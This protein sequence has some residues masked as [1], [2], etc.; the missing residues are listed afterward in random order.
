M[1]TTYTKLFSSIT[2]STVW[3]EDDHTRLVWITMLAMADK[4]GRIWASV[5]GLADRARVPVES[6]RH[7]LGR[8]TAPD[9]DSR[10]KEH[11][12]RRVEPIDGGWRLLNHGKYRE[13]RD[14]EAERERKR[15]WARKK[16]AGVKN[17]ENVDAKVDGIDA[18]DRYVDGSRHK[19]EASPDASA[20]PEEI[21]NTHTSGAC[22]GSNGHAKPDEPSPVPKPTESA[23]DA[24]KRPTAEAPRPPAVQPPKGPPRADG[25]PAT[26]TMSR[27]ADQV[28][29]AIRE[30]EAFAE[31]A[32]RV[33]DKL[34]GQAMGKKPLPW[35]LAAVRACGEQADIAAAAGH[36]WALAYCLDRLGRYVANAKAPK[37]DT[38]TR[39][40]LVASIGS[41]RA[42]QRV[43]PETGY[44]HLTD[45]QGRPVQGYDPKAP[46][47]RGLLTPLPAAPDNDEADEVARAAG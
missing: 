46:W 37:D 35:V 36:P 2:E 6:C 18:V 43:D 30:H 12:G 26:G 27:D 22:T 29:A 7:A 40:G 13:A 10:T 9:P 44:V 4:R 19:A 14:E 39:P 17:A 33:A 34:W 47:L 5:P 23:Q 32:D 21:Q 1:S 38:P 11:E 31:V 28:L 25:G 16:R 15:E 45:R 24:L 41:G 42:G 3:R 20:S 8:L